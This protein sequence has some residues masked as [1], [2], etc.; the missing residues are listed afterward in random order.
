LKNYFRPIGIVL[1]SVVGITSFT[2]PFGKAKDVQP[3]RPLLQGAQIEAPVLN[4]LKRSC[5]NCHS[6]QTTWPWYSYVGP[7][8]WL[9]ERDVQ[10]GRSHFNM[11]R[12][13][14]YGPDDRLQ[15]LGGISTMV[16]NGDMPL[17]QYVLLHPDA[18]LSQDEVKLLDQWGHEER[19]RL[20]TPANPPAQSPANSPTQ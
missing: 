8:S 19:K 6:E 4:V 20:R 16:R 7:V 17:P 11:S 1:L 14:E 10:E 5:Q 9:V 2:H 3:T 13:A 12:W 18:K 15:M